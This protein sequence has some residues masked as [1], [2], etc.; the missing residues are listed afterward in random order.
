MRLC[1]LTRL[2]VCLE[3]ALPKACFLAGETWMPLAKFAASAMDERDDTS[4]QTFL[5]LQVSG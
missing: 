2:L 1:R 3:D 4:E 5:F